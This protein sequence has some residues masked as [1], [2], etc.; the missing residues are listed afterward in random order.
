MLFRSCI[1]SGD[2]LVNLSYQELRNTITVK[3]RL[4][5]SLGLPDTLRV[6]LGKVVPLEAKPV[7]ATGKA[8]EDVEI[9]L[10]SADDAILKV[11]KGNLV[12]QAVG[13]TK[14]YVEGAGKKLE[15]TVT[16]VRQ[17]ITESVALH[18]GEGM[19]WAV[20]PGKYE[21]SIQVKASDASNNGVVLTWVNNECPE[22]AEGQDLHQTCNLTNAASLIV[23]NPTQ[24]SLGPQVVGLINVVQVP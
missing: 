15:I 12:P 16:V 8:V 3:C 23:T 11:G 2:A 4:V 5:A 13:V 1:G 20:P 6:D 18:D 19:T 9:R 22:L 7:D 14:L 24:F 17:V 10:A 21:V